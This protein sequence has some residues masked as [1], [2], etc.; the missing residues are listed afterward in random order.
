MRLISLMSFQKYTLFS[1]VV[2]LTSCA[3]NVSQA[4]K[5]QTDWDEYELNGR[6]KELTIKTYKAH[7]ESG[8]LVKDELW[9][10]KVVEFSPEGKLLKVERKGESKETYSYSK[11]QKIKSCFSA[12]NALTSRIVTNYTKW[13]AIKSI[14]YYNAS[15]V[16]TARNDYTYDQKRQLVERLYQ[17][18]YFGYTKENYIEFDS[19]GH[20]IRCERY[21]KENQLK[22]IEST[23]YDTNGRKILNEVDRYEGG[24]YAYGGSSRYTYNA[25]GFICVVESATNSDEYHVTHQISYVYDSNGNYITKYTLYDWWPN[26]EERTIIYY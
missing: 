16:E 7:E 18:N 4:Q 12:D 14:V 26:I 2:L 24:A 9:S 3:P 19:A 6:I 20:E 22:E 25:E 5:S 15:G 1:I 8:S 21:N 17:D 23:T 11:T 10:T 13:G